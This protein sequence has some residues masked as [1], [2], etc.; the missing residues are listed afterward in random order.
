MLISQTH[1][2][3]A[4]QKGTPTQ[5]GVNSPFRNRQLEENLALFEEMKAGKHPEGAH[6]LTR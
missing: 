2:R 4:D 3:I 6:V 5:A 1:P